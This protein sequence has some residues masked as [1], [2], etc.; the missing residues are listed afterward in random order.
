LRF[1][2]PNLLVE[3]FSVFSL[4]YSRS[5]CRFERLSVSPDLLLV[6]GSITRT[7]EGLFVAEKYFFLHETYG[8]KCGMICGAI[9][10]WWIFSQCLFYVEA[11]HLNPCPMQPLGRLHKNLFWL[12]CLFS[13]A[14]RPKRLDS[15]LELQ[16]GTTHQSQRFPRGLRIPGVDLVGLGITPFP[17]SVGS[18]GDSGG[19]RGF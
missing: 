14:L 9:L 16:V 8:P 3:A 6:F 4:I 5:P 17:S 19:L 7:D 1:F 12:S 2:L 15:R 10:D 13:D 18:S 11:P